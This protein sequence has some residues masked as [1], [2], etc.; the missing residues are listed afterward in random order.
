M[1]KTTFRYL[2][3]FIIL[4]TVTYQLHDTITELKLIPKGIVKLIF[5]EKKSKPIIKNEDNNNQAEI[6]NANSYDL[7][8]KKIN[9]FSGYNK[10]SDGKM[11]PQHKSA[12]L[13]AVKKN[14]TNQLELYTRDGFLITKD[15]VE[16]FELPK[17]YDVHNSQ[18]GIRGIFYFNNQRYAYMATL[19]IGCQTMS[20]INLDENIEIFQA[21]CLPNYQDVHYDGVGGASIHT[22]DN[23]LLSIGAPT[24]SS[25]AIRNLA[26]NDK[27]FYGKIISINKQSIKNFY[28]KKKKIEIKIFTKGHRNP[29]GLARINNKFFSAEHGPKG[30]DELNILEEGM[31]FGWP[32]SSYGTKYESLAVASY[33][34]N[35]TKHGFTEPLM[36]F[37]PSIAISDLT[38]CSRKMVLYYEREGC[39]IGTTLRD[40]SLIVIL[41]NEDLNRVIGYEKIEFGQRLRHI[42]KNTNGELFEEKDGSIYV[43]SDSGDVLNILFKLKKE[44]INNE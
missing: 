1:I 20:I 29:Q 39:L 12:A 43:T 22:V 44:K 27:S 38:N 30:G 23:I 16:D 9:Y 11:N 42:G 3:F 8:V 26:Q 4:V 7:V 41:L 17:T 10:D 18:G 24:N 15:G 25:K 32:I 31:N 6:I 28:E 5:T 37:T 33:K 40:Q 13:Y 36:Q 2:I 35:H 14:N 19:K 21:D 34:L